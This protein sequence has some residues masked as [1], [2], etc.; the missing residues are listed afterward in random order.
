MTYEQLVDTQYDDNFKTPDHK[1]GCEIICETIKPEDL[2][3]LFENRVG[4]YNAY[5]EIKDRTLT[6][7]FMHDHDRNRAI[8]YANDFEQP[9]KAFQL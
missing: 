8:R 9:A 1:F 6:A 2:K 7:I 5:V 4:F 3:D